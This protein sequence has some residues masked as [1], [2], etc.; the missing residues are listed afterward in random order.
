MAEA[1]PRTVWPPLRAPRSRTP[2]SA[3]L[4]ESSAQ[5]RALSNALDPNE[6]I[7]LLAFAND[8]DLAPDGIVG[9]ESSPL[10]ADTALVDIEAPGPNQA[11]GFPLRPGHPDRRHE[12]YERPA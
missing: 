3:E 10:L 6:E 5:L 1:V 12:V 9:R 7:V 8:E 11:H 2:T 4:S